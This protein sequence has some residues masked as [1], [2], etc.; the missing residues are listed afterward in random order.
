MSLKC[1]PSVTPV[2][3]SLVSRLK[4]ERE[5]RE[6]RER[7]R[8]EELLTQKGMDQNHLILVPSYLFIYF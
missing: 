8:K 4:D 2:S 3:A 5:G 7:R 6:L 1:E